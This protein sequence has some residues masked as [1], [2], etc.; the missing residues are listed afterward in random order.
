MC[1]ITVKK[2]VNDDDCGVCLSLAIYCLI[3]GLDCRTIPPVKFNNQAHLFMLHTVMGF[4]FD[5]YGKYD[6]AFD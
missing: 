2:Q 4:Q 1:A 6:H 5:Q 3:H